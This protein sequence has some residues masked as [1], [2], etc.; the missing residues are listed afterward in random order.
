MSICCL[1]TVAQY[2]CRLL[3]VDIMRALRHNQERSAYKL[4]FLSFCNLLQTVVTIH[5]CIMCGARY[6][7]GHVIRDA[8]C[9]HFVLLTDEGTLASK[10]FELVVCAVL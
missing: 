1:Q 8:P 6:S 10:R 9:L 4:I 3:G 2:L 7:G 5:C